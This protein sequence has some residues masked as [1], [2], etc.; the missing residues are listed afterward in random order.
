MADLDH[1]GIAQLVLRRFN[2]PQSDELRYI[3]LVDSALRQLSYDVARD[4]KLRYWLF[5]PR[6]TTTATLDADGVADLSTLITTPR[7]LLECLQHG[8][9]YPPASTGITQPMR[10]IDNP[11]MG[12]LQGAYDG[13]V[14]KCWLEG[15]DLHTRSADGNANP[16]TGSLAFEVPYWASLTQLPDSLVQKLVWG[17]YWSDTP[18]TEAK[19]AAA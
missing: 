3:A 5:T 12:Q 14:L 11:G 4:P 10:L 1:S 6:T 15:P 9:I 8:N 13:L 17:P 18:M 19:G 16:L 7:I 2:G